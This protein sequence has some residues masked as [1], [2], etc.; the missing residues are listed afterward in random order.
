MKFTTTQNT[1]WRPGIGRFPKAWIEY[2]G[3]SHEE[4]IEKYFYDNIK[5]WDFD[6]AGSETHDFVFEDD[7][8]FRLEYTWWAEWY[9]ED[10]DENGLKDEMH[11]FEI[12]IVEA[13]VLEKSL[14]RDWL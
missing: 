2:P 5:L 12:S 13:N 6:I 14:G 11:I 10:E 9:N 8:A 7:K 4:T 3:L 1:G